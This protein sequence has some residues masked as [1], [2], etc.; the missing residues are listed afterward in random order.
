ML[1]FSDKKMWKYI[2]LEYGHTQGMLLLPVLPIC[3]AGNSRSEKPPECSAVCWCLK[4]NLVKYTP[5][6]QF[7]ELKLD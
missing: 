3:T 1:F 2:S 6:R 4:Q 5:K 7:Y